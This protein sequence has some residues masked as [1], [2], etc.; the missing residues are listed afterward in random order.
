[1]KRMPNIYSRAVR[2]V[3]W[4]GPQSY[5]SA[6]A[7]ECV[8]TVSSN[9]K[10]DWGT[11]TMV[12]FSAQSEAFWID[13]DAEL[14][15]SEAQLLAVSSLLSRS[16]FN[17]LWIWQ[18]IRLA[19]DAI[20]M[21]GP[22]SVP[23]S[24]IR[25]TV[26]RI[27]A[28]IQPQFFLENFSR[29]QQEIL[30]DLCKGNRFAAFRKLLNQTKTCLCSDPR[31]KIFALL[32]LIRPA[33]KKVE[34]E[35]DYA[36]NVYEVY[37]DV[38][39]RFMTAGH[40]QLLSTI[41]M[42]E[43]LEGVPSWVPD[44]ASPRLSEPLENLG[45]AAGFK[46]IVKFPQ[47]GILK[48]T[49]VL[50][51]VIEYAEA[52]N[53]THDVFAGPQIIMS[54]IIGL[55]RVVGQMG[56]RDR[57][58][59]SKQEFREL[60]K[61]LCNN[62]VSDQFYPSYSGLFTLQSSEEFLTELLNLRIN[63][64]DINVNHEALAFLAQSLKF[65]KGRSLFR[66]AQGRFGQA[67]KTARAGDIVTVVLGLKSAL[68]LRPTNDNK[69]QVVGEAYY[70]GMMEGEALLGPLPDGIEEIRRYS[71]SAQK[72]HVV[73][74]DRNN[75]TVSVVDPR[76]GDMPPNWKIES[77]PEDEV[78]EWFVNEE[79]GKRTRNDPR[80]TLE[81]LKKRGVDLQVFDLI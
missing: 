68:V 80:R 30:Y 72:W 44:W 22:Q 13:R 40:L 66:S 58:L 64:E 7:L 12:P 50:V 43:H 49:G 17:R 36:K 5:D 47:R 19:R 27:Y 75:N 63:S 34:I 14:P 37:Q 73:Y 18:E 54:A 11:V 46:A 78:R 4:L 21:C 6:L 67:P 24:A 32:S 10:V 41:E 71:L 59:R 28:G 3:V 52:F 57:S 48:V 16:W 38:M 25:A 2:V 51:G 62:Q 70:S 33:E 26:F 1:V 15:F 74:F 56:F 8:E 77:D 65:Y 35:V 69:F 76:L 39:V 53:L 60:C 20:A 61:T 42:H 81:L 79:T 9:I 55:Q 23:W 45:A 31:D 29:E